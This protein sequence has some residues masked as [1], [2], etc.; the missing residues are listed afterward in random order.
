MTGDLIY[1]RNLDVRGVAGLLAIGFR[2]TDD[3]V[4][5]WTARFNAFKYGEGGAISG[6]CRVLPACLAARRGGDT[7]VV[8]V[9]AISSHETQA[10]PDAPIS[11]LGSAIT[12]ATD[13]E[14]RPDLLSKEPHRP[15]HG[16]RS[17]EERD[18]EVANRYTAREVSGQA[19]AFLILDDIC[20]RGSTLAEITRALREFNPTWRTYGL[21]LAKSENRSWWSGQGEDISNSHIPD[22]LVELWDG[23]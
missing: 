9:A 19:G 21:V 12:D 23:E 15:L 5:P 14:W 3:P 18:A 16:L 11:I 6:A 1:L 20:T 8:M 2:F 4:D 13:W 10:P 7:R 17:A 22:H